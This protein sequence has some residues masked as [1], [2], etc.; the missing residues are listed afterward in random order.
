VTETKRWLSDIERS[1]GGRLTMRTFILTWNPDR[2]SYHEYLRDVRTTRAGLPV[3]GGWSTGIRRHGISEGDRAF[4]LRQHRERGVVAAGDFASRIYEGEHWDPA[5]P[6]PTTWYADVSFDVVLDLD[7]RLPIE[8][9]KSEI[10]RVVW[11][12]MQGSG[13]EVPRASAERLEDLW[14]HH[15]ER[16]GRAQPAIAEEARGSDLF[17]EGALSRIM[18]NRYERDPHARSACIEHWGLQCIVCRFDYETAYGDVGID[19]IEVHHLRELSTIGARYRVDPVKDL[20]PVCANCHAMLHR[21]RPAYTIRWLRRQLRTS[22]V[23]GPAE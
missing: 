3:Q 6:E 2:W 12:R 10:P 11:D 19:Y 20:R 21:R 16:S 14:Q 8:V 22:G 15:L 13:V 9:L 17:A 5:A 4:L 18:V 1:I 7:D 23:A